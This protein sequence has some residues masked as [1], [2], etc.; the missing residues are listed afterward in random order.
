MRGE[1][2][3]PNSPN[4]S[5]PFPFVESFKPNWQGETTM[6][7]A[8]STSLTRVP[9]LTIAVLAKRFNQALAAGESGITTTEVRGR[10]TE[11]S[12]SRDMVEAMSV[13]SLRE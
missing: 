11:T 10:R 4:T 1:M 8:R 7:S 6:R 5:E 2:Y 13:F 3:T 12:Y 9:T